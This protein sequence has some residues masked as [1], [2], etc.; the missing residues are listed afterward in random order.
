MFNIFVCSLTNYF[1]VS[2]NSY[3]ILMSYVLLLY[4]SILWMS[5]SAT[6]TLSEIWHYPSFLKEALLITEQFYNHYMLIFN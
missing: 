5:V 1:A 3:V 2:I 4:L 6:E